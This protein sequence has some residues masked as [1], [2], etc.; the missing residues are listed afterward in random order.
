[1]FSQMVQHKREEFEWFAS[2]YDGI[3]CVFLFFFIIKLKIIYNATTRN[4][5][6]FFTFFIPFAFAFFKSIH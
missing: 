2:P 3:S 5:F 6:F 4:N 1:M